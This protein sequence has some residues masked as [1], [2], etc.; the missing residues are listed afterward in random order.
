MDESE[1]VPECATRMIRGVRRLTILRLVREV[2]TRTK[3]SRLQGTAQ[4][5]VSNGASEF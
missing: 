1:F 5:E 4:S 3:L 2:Q